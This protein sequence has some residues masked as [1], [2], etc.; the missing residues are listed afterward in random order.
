MHEFIGK[1]YLGFICTIALKGKSTHNTI[2]GD[3]ASLNTA[4]LL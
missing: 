3:Q 1:T 2:T 4:V